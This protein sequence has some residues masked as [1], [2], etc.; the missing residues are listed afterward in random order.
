M[1]QE[2]Q[3]V[4][5]GGEVGM[6]ESARFIRRLWLGALLLNLLVVAFAAQT[7]YSSW[8]SH[9]ERADIATRNLSQTLEHELAGTLANIDITL[10]SLTDSHG[11]LVRSGSLS[12]NDW[13]AELRQKRSRLPILSGIRA[14]DAVGAVIYGLEAGDPINANVPDRAYFL[15]HR[16]HPEAGLFISEPILSRVTKKWSIVLSRRVSDRDGK[17]AGV[18]AATIPLDRFKERFASLQ[19]GAKGSIGLRDDR[20]HLIVRYPELVGGGQIGST[21]VAKEFSAALQRDRNVGSYDAGASSIDGIRRHH[22]YRRN[23]EYGFYINVGIAEDEYLSSWRT[24]LLPTVVLLGIFMLA[25]L[26]FARQLQRVWLQ[27][28]ESSAMLR[29]SKENFQAL[30]EHAP[31]GVAL[32]NADGSVAYV[33]PALEQMLGYSSEDRLD[34]RSWWEKAYPDPAYREMVIDT[35]RKLVLAPAAPGTV[36]RTFT[37]RRADGE[38]RSIRFMVVKMA[39]GRITVIFEDFTLRMQTEEALQ[40]SERFLLDSQSVAGLGSY[41]L[42]IA[43]GTWKS[44]SVFDSLFGIDTSFPHTVEGWEALLHPDDR[45]MMSSYFRDE[46]LGRC[47]PFDKSYRIRRHADGV[48]RWVHGL[49]R[50]EVDAA[51]HPVKMIGTIQDVTERKAAEEQLQ[52]A[53]N[54]FTHALEG[55]MITTTDATIIDVNAA[56]TRITGYR[57]EEVLGQSPRMLRSGRQTTEFYAA[58]WREL[59]EKGHWYGEIWNRRK[60]GD[61]Y[62]Q[63]QTISSVRDGRGAVSNYVA[64]FTDITA[65]KEHERQLEHIAHYDALTTLPNRVL[66]A[67]RLQQAMSQAQRR[68]QSLAVAYLDLDGFKLVNDRHGHEVG[69][70]LLITIAARMKQTLREGDTLARLGGDEF[71][72]VLL[73]LADVAASV[74]MLTRLLDATSQPFQIGD[75]VLQVTASI[76]V[77]FYPQT[78]EVD[79]DQLLRQADQAMYQA[80]LAGKSRYHVFDAEQDRS[81]RGHHES[82]EG[83]RAAL[84]ENQFVLHYQ[85]K[86]NMRSGKVIGAEALI[87]WQ[88]PQRGLLP[89][90]VFLPVIEDHPLAVRLGEWV[91]DTALRQMEQWQSAG[92]DI[93]VSVNVGARQLQQ[94]DFVKCLQ[95][96]L[97]RHPTIK[98]GNL[99]LEVLET[100]ALEDMVQVSGIIEKCRELGVSFALDDFGTGYS[101]LTYLKRLPVTLLKIDQSFVHD[102]LEDPDDL[103]ILEGV[104]GLSAAFRRQAIAEGVE[105]DEH[106]IMLLQLGCELAQGFGIARPMP[107]AEL[108]AWTVSWRP[109]PAWLGL[110]SVSRNDLPLLFASVEHRAW[111]AAV[112]SYVR[113]EREVVPPMNMLHCHFGAWLRTDGAA[114]FEGNDVFARMVALHQD[115]HELASTLCDL[116]SYRRTDEALARLYELHQLKDALLECLHVLMRENRQA[117]K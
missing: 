67:D 8:R 43:T 46:V 65:L 66:L 31:Y 62:A 93:P 86:V 91:I 29:K 63:M 10:A 85:P 28:Q 111:I 109:D 102:M 55:I 114:R 5:D 6:T 87:R 4:L 9:L 99:E 18:V 22:S 110:Q 59:L 32:L 19:L 115:V 54:V 64:V 40:E 78:E 61:V 69:D 76:G 90:A 1:S 45:Q 2:I 17:F 49:G 80:K 72:A 3:T 13:N 98:P 35:W 101:S 77:T 105:T 34:R 7:V 50:L 26:L 95:E 84:E 37:V 88:H 21:T 82:L 42:D 23:A 39:D 107:A 71:V 57:R 89:P 117:A 12:A 75:L 81:V 48:T 24:E 25:T 16:D 68:A 97:A 14:T 15:F 30:A 74:P 52:L 33:N 20:L 94:P 70:Q 103:A 96:I 92:F 116:H 104:I 113:S 73:D 53:A 41:S 44:S 51:G 100:S 11:R 108:P 60:N 58:M 36:E 27:Q 38:Q 79:A 47:Q 83:I 106:G 56:F 112:E